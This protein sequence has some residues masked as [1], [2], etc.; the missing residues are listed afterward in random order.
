MIARASDYRK[1]V[2][3][4]V[5]VRN[6]VGLKWARLGLDYKLGELAP[7]TAEAAERACETFRKVGLTAH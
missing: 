3:D 4:P 6:T 7:P 5:Q 2:R 1:M